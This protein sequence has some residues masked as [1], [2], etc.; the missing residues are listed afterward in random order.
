MAVSSRPEE[1]KTGSTSAE[2]FSPPYLFSG[3][4]PTITA[5]AD[6]IGY[7][8]TF[9]IDTP[10]GSAVSQVTLVRLGAVTHSF[11]MSQ[12]FNRLS[13]SAGLGRA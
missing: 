2:V 13:F 12:R 1:I 6:T 3:S 4:R 9:R 11:N 5:A 7:G 8:D 10:D